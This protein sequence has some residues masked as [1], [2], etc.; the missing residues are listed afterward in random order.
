MTMAGEGQAQAQAQAHGRDKHTVT[1]HEHD[2]WYSG[3]RWMASAGAWLCT[4]YEHKATSRASLHPGWK[5]G[6]DVGLTK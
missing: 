2:G 6:V 3:R 1:E 5:W 4:I